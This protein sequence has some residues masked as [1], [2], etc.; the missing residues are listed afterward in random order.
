MNA[1]GYLFLQKLEPTLALQAVQFDVM[2][3]YKMHLV[4][5]KQYNMCMCTISFV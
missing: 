1:I 5:P 2:F 3:L 4:K